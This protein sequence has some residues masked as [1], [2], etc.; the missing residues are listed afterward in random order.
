MMIEEKREEQILKKEKR[1]QKD[2]CELVV[3]PEK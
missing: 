3:S 2:I 1:G